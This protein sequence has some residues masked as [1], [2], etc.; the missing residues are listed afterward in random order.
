MSDHRL[1]TLIHACTDEPG[2]ES[3]SQG[4]D[5]DQW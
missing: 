2:L 1:W 5:A 3:A 4:N